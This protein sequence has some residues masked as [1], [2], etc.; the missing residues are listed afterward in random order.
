M[1]DAFVSLTLAAGPTLPIYFARGTS[2]APVTS[3]SFVVTSATSGALVMVQVNEVPY[4]VQVAPD[5]TATGPDSVTETEYKLPA[6]VDAARCR[7]PK[8]GKTTKADLPPSSL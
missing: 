7:S 4:R 8:S 2:F 3:V 6:A 5:A 1:P